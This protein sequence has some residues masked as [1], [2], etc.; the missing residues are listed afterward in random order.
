MRTQKRISYVAS[1]G[2]AREREIVGRFDAREIEQAV[3]G[4]VSSLPSW[5]NE[6]KP[7]RACQT[8][9]TIIGCASAEADDDFARAVRLR[10]R[11]AFRPSRRWEALT[12]FRSLGKGTGD[13]RRRSFQD[14]KED[15]AIQA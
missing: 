7:K 2:D 3:T 4:P 14:R 8:E 1:S 9:T 12:G 10:Q 5:P 13:R 15:C 6:A 11:A